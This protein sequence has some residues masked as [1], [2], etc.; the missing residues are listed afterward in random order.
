M[1]LEFEQFNIK[2]FSSLKLDVTS[3]LDKRLQTFRW[4]SISATKCFKFKEI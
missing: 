3:V 1:Q 2:N 4:Y